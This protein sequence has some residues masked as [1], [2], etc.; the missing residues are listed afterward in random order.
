MWHLLVTGRYYVDMLYIQGIYIYATLSSY[1]RVK[2][3]IKFYCTIYLICIRRAIWN[4]L[5]DYGFSVAFIRQR[6]SDNTDVD[7]GDNTGYYGPPANT[8]RPYIS[9]I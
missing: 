8:E 7:G 9:D 1:D 4:K 5:N 3:Y 6:L 2:Y